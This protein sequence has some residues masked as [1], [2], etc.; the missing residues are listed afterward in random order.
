MITKKIQVTRIYDWLEDSKARINI[1]RG[2][3]GSSKSY[4]LSQFFILNKLLSQQN[5]TIVIAR[6]TLPAL[7]KTAFKETMDLIKAWGIPH[8][9]NKTDLELNLNNN[10]CYFMSVDDPDKI[11]SLQTDDVWLEEAVDFTFED[12]HQ[13]NM[14]CNGQLYLS[15]NP[16]DALCY[17]KTKIIDSGNY[18]VVEDIS[19]Y[20]DN[21]FLPE[22]RRREIV[23]LINVDDSYYKVYNLGEWGVLKNIIYDK[24]KLYPEPPKDGIKNITMGIDWGFESPAVLVKTYWLDGN[25]FISEEKIYKRNL[26]TPAF[27]EEVKRA[28]LDDINETDPK[29]R[30][31]LLRQEM[32]RAFYAGT[33]EPGS[34]QQFYDAGFNIHKAVTDV[35]DGIN[36]CKSHIEGIIGSNA[37]KEIQGY[38]R[39]ED[40]DGNVKEEPVKF[41]DH[42]CDAMRYSVY[43]IGRNY[44]DESDTLN[45]SLR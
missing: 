17:I 33:D 42:F 45:F 6:K 30:E 2:G 7:K 41:N 16:V 39:M 37:V 9:L 35:R 26:T 31:L 3:T 24:W 29:K 21:P 32:D 27:I 13:F 12:F 34:I 44:R 11:A 20:R 5:K 1:L 15:F 10:V 38:K 23:N 22:V 14:R 18:D 36:F 40:K 28:L 4:S 8:Q 25:K 19:T 43:S